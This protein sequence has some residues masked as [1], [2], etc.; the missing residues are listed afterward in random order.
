MVIL[1]WLAGFGCP[2]PGAERWKY[3]HRPDH[4]RVPNM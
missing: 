1:E 4:C 2:A 3:A